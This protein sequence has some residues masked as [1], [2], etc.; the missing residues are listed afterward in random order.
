[1]GFLDSIILQQ[2]EQG[3]YKAAYNM[4]GTIGKILFYLVTLWYIWRMR[5]HPLKAIPIAFL[6]LNFAL[7]WNG[8]LLFILSGFKEGDV[9]NLAVAFVY[10][11]PVGWL[12]AKLFRL[13][14]QVVTEMITL[15]LLA[16]H[17][18]ARSGCLFTGC[19]HGYSNKWGVYSLW[20]DEYVFPIVL[21]ESLMTLCI[22]VFLLIRMGRK[23]YVPDG[24]TMPWMLLLYGIGRFYTEYFHDNEKIWIGCS[25]I[26]F[27][28][29]FMAAVGFAMLIWLSFRPCRQGNSITNQ[30]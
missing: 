26:A 5:L 18:P 30:S 23:T 6:S 13:R 4:A 8:I 24:R 2:I 19:C 17:I 28:S 21:V 7:N 14:W 9:S 22:L 10:L 16:F 25:D 27:H 3:T 1:M 12:L 29:L 15:V 20:A 11:L